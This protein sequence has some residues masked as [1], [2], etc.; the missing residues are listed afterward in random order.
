MGSSPTFPITCEEGVMFMNK[1]LLLLALLVLPTKATAQFS[2]PNPMPSSVSV[3]VTELTDSTRFKISWTAVNGYPS[4]DVLT[5]SNPRK[6]ELEQLRLVTGT[7]WTITVP[8]N[9]IPDGTKFYVSV[10]VSMSS[11]KYAAITYHAPPMNLNLKSL[12]TKP[13]SL[14]STDPGGSGPSINQNGKLLISGDM[15]SGPAQQYCTFV[16]F[17]DGQIAMRIPDKSVSYCQTE[18]QNFP[19]S[20]RQPTAAQQSVADTIR[21]NYTVERVN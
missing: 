4:Y 12:M 17:E 8:R 18:Y 3:K 20:L 13:D 16:E 10:R 19:V 1:I 15:P 6:F 14:S 9:V 11:P 5:F 7:S 21:I 2:V